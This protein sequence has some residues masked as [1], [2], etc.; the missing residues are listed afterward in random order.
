MATENNNR[1]NSTRQPLG[2]LAKSTL[3]HTVM[4]RIYSPRNVVFLFPARF[5]LSAKKPARRRRHIIADLHDFFF[6]FV[7]LLP[8]DGGLCR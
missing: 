5:S 4:P 7:F 6:C 2:V 1:V 3:T 8:A